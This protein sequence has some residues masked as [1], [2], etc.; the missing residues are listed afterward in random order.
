MKALSSFA[1]LCAVA[2]CMVGC[3]SSDAP[4][5]VAT[6]STL[7]P[8]GVDEIAP[9]EAVS[10]L[11]VDIE[12]ERAVIPVEAESEEPIFTMP[13]SIE[14]F[15]GDRLVFGINPYAN[16]AR[17]R[18]DVRELSVFNESVAAELRTLTRFGIREVSTVKPAEGITHLLDWRASLVHVGDT[19]ECDV[20]VNLADVAKKITVA[21]DTFSL[22]IA[23]PQKGAMIV[24]QL[25][26]L[27]RQV[28]VMIVKSLYARFPYQGPIVAADETDLFVLE[29]GRFQGVYEGMQ[30]LIYAEVEGGVFVP[31]AYADAK[32][33]STRTNLTPW[34]FNKKDPLAKSIA[35][36]LDEDSEAFQTY[37][38]RAICV[39]VTHSPLLRR[40]IVD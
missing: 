1:L 5:A 8:L 10:L 30:F 22:N 38:L 12:T 4:T 7:N 36:N 35:D 9:E 27:G 31:L 2:L 32:P 33:G 19:L 37:N 13:A 16:T 28:G 15:G 21:Q 26:A 17:G 18:M 11:P 39:G 14:G 24:P 6:D 34:A 29:G 20:T 40:R 3:A 23:V 25:H